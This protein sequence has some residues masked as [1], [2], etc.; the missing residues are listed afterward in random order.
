MSMAF[1][2]SFL[3][4]TIVRGARMTFLS[5]FRI[6]TKILAVIGLLSVIAAGITGLGI[7]AMKSLSESSAA[8]DHVSGQT[9][10]AARM[11]QNIIALSR[12]E[13]R[14]VSDPR[15]DNRAAVQKDIDEE[16]RR[17]ET[18]FKNIQGKASDAVKAKL[19]PLWALWMDY[20]K[21]LATTLKAAEAVS[22]VQMPDEI[23][24]LRDEAVGSAA[25]A[26]KLRDAGREL[27]EILEKSAHET[28][29]AAH[30]EFV[31]VSRLMVIAAALGIALGVLLGFLVGQ[32]GVAKPIRNLVQLLQRL[33]GG[34][35]DIAIT[36]ADRRDE[37]GEVAKTALVFKDNGLAKLRM[38]QEQ[39]EAD[40]RVAAQ[41]SADMRRLADEF[42]GAVGT[43]VESVSSAS[44]ELEAAAGSLTKTAETTQQLSTTVASASEEASANVQSVASA[45]EE[46]ASSVT[47]IA[48]QV[49]ESAT[50][51]DQAVKQ[52][53][54][55]DASIVEL[56]NA[57]ARIGEVVQL[58]TDI[59][60]QTNL[61]ALNA[62][63]EAARAGEA[64]RG[65]A[66][67]ASEVK[68]LAAQTAK[69]TEEIG[70]Q[71]GG[72]QTATS[73]AVTAI[74][75]ISGTIERISEISSVIAAAVEEQGAATQE[76]ARNVQQAAHGTTQV[77][78][79]ITQVNRGAD[80]TGSAST[81]V[82]ASAQSLSGESNRLRLEV[83]RFLS[84]VRAA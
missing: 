46:L 79:T 6:L 55:T 75:E 10:L 15:P 73:E 24:K 82:L 33:A 83:D 44:T 60:A 63:I 7:M 31:R 9:V 20:Q 74:K 13:F 45:S 26:Q 50:I 32:F 27:V 78:T 39:R 68:A 40:A 2:S 76:I 3:D 41:R 36:G 21:E 66:V 30:E 23:A 51:A 67:V 47:E 19:P 8:I 71:I 77:A 38:E 37:V 53:A 5:R 48:R 18:R 58:I 22:G 12:A 72:M 56:S 59:A 1:A 49:Q 11:V 65:F 54:K 34:D 70:T 81:Q 61:L 64:G 16:K 29:E 25:I 57:A 62:T 35:Y 4:S 42:Q 43:I 52:A 17:F 14:V 28:A 80:D 84:T 69:A